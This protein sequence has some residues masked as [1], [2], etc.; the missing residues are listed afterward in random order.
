MKIKL[1]DLVEDI[2]PYGFIGFGITAPIALHM[3]SASRFLN[4]SPAFN[5]AAMIGLGVSGVC[6]LMA[7]GG[8]IQIYRNGDK[9]VQRAVTDRGI[10][11][12]AAP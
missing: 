3:A 4:M 10:E 11:P 9:R 2:G 12:S 5:K 8:L 6:L 7:V 1:G